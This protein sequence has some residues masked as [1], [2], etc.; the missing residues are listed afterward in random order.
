M[1]STTNSSYV[2]PVIKSS[3]CTPDLCRVRIWATMV[4]LLLHR[5]PAVAYNSSTI[6]QVHLELFT[7]SSTA[8]VQ[9]E[10]SLRTS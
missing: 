1:I 2:V 4:I 10:Y 8:I 7:T 6:Y 9:Y 3:N 5:D